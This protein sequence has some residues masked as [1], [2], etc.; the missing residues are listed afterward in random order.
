MSPEG[1]T[2]ASVPLS[3][4]IQQHPA[5]IDAYIRHGWKL[6]PIPP[7]S[8][9]PTTPGW[10][11]PE[12]TLQSEHQLP[13]F[14]GIGLCHAYSGTMALDIDNWEMAKQ[15][16]A[17]HGIDINQLYN[18][19]DAVQIQSG[20]PG[21]GKL[22]FTMPHHSILKTK[23]IVQNGI[24]VLE[25]RCATANGNT[26]QDVLPPSIHP[27]TNQPYRWGG[28]GHWNRLPL[29][30]DELYDMWKSLIDAEQVRNISTFTTFDA[31]WEEIQQALEFIHPD[32]DREEWILVG[33]ALHHAGSHTNQLDDAYSLYD[34]WSQGTSEQPSMKYDQSALNS[35]W[36][37]FKP[38]GGI[39]IGSLFEVAKRHGWKRAQPTAQDLFANIDI[40]ENSD[41]QSLMDLFRPPM[42]TPDFSLFPEVLSTRALELADSVG[43]DPL[44]PL[45]A[46]LATVSGAVNAKSRLELMPGF[47]VPPVLWIMTI[48]DPADKKSPG[49]KPMMSVLRDIEKDDR[50]RYKKEML[51]WEALEARHVEERKDFIEFARQPGELITAN[52]LIPQ[53]TDLPP[54]PVP[55]KIIISDITSQKLVRNAAER[56]EGLLCWL[57]EMNAWISKIVNKQSG[58]DRSA[59]VQGYEADFY[60]MDRVSSGPIWCDNLAISMYGN[61][62]P[63]VLHEAFRQMG[64]DGLLQRFVPICLRPGMTKLGNP[65]PEAFSSKPLWDSQIWKIHKTSE[66]LFRMDSLSYIEFRAFQQWYETVKMEDRAILASD[67]YMTAFGKLEGLAG[68]M[69]LLFHLLTNPE[70]Q[71]IPVQT[72]KNAVEVIKTFIVPSLRYAW[73][74]MGGVVDESFNYWIMQHIL[75]L[76]GTTEQVTL[77]ELKHSA[78][79]QLVNIPSWEKDAR[80][81]DAMIILEESK[82]VIQSPE[83]TRRD[84]VVWYINPQLKDV[85]AKQ[86]KQ[87]IDI[88]Q[89]RLDDNRK[90]ALKGGKPIEKRFYPGFEG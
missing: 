41:P 20:K 78:R 43:C 88:R 5:S 23:K 8:K 7:G 24:T 26:I 22:L 32:C 84:H 62:Q 15:L 51:E 39:A 29:I 79:K 60:E 27:E 90:I 45:F 40:L 83:Q 77:R 67:V 63:K 28:N 75:A 55:K 59:W 42:P 81:S 76:S 61:V 2:S 12:Y 65:I 36:R 49:S 85:Y 48:G 68:R 33:M 35:A 11:K 72:T 19:N 9:G 74:D 10:N 44:V 66:T 46:G 82:W 13:K 57:D 3:G 4:N 18:A 69:I 21:R 16:L 64:T 53:V 1:N 54:K 47:R 31:S 50:D 80:V 30:P 56:P 37:S 89:K 38:D 14:Y 25:F 34:T 6:V 87:V 70:Q 71:T 86:R 17:A 58:E 73:G 52:E